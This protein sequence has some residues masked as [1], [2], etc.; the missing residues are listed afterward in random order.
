MSI[1]EK[2][3][4]EL[5][6]KIISDIAVVARRMDVRCKGEIVNS[7]VDSYDYLT[8]R[9]M[10]RR[11]VPLE[12]EHG[13]FR[14]YSDILEGLTMILCQGTMPS[15]DLILGPLRGSTVSSLFPSSFPYQP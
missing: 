9:T 15:R 10:L 4:P 5:V 11:V 12:D 3:S 6:K 14:Y 1:S 2:L 13:E 8:P 7:F